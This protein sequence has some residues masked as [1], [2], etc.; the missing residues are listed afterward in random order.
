MHVRRRVDVNQRPDAGDD[1]NHHRRE[2]IERERDVDAEAARRDPGEQRLRDHALLRRARDQRQDRRH[3]HG[4]RQQDRSTRNRGRNRLADAATPESVQREPDERK[5]RDERQHH[6]F[7]SVNESGFSDSRCRNR[8]M[9]IARPTAASAAATVITKNTMIWPSATPCMR[10]NATKARLTAF[11]MIS[12]DSRIV[13][14][15]RRTNTPAVPMLKSTAD[16]T[17]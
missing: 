10:P 2:R 3:R 12:I 6:H 16:S 8:L 1:E 7:N 15:L 14:R 13:I 9:T 11:N 17:R 4:E 5:E